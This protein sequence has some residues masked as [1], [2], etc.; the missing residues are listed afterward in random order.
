MIP[1]GE[2]LDAS[3]AHAEGLMRARGYLE[4][5]ITIMLPNENWRE[6]GSLYVLPSWSRGYHGETT[7]EG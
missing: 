1:R 2:L 3:A 4:P 5:V 7:R 6:A